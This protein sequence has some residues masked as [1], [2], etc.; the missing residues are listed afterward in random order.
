MSKRSTQGRCVHCLGWFSYLTDDH[1]FPK[2]WYP[3]TTSEEMPKWKVPSCKSC[4]S[5]LGKIEEDLMLRLGLCVNRK[6]ARASGISEKVLRALDPDA[7]D[8]KRDKYY[9]Q[10]TREKILKEMIS[11]PEIPIGI[12]PNFGPKNNFSKTHCGIKI[13][14]RELKDLGEKI[15][16]G[17]QY[18]IE[19]KYVENDYLIEI[20]FVH[21]KDVQKVINL[22]NHHGKKYYRGPGLT[23]VHAPASDDNMVALYIIEI[24]GQLKIYGAIQN[25]SLTD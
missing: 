17:H 20:I 13:P 9:R 12:L 14:E 7:A 5:S 22:I 8:G 25:V 10:K 21:D 15:I 4:N 19:K 24:W 11:L 1:V 3:D 6:S 23:I 16:R 2:S 18:V